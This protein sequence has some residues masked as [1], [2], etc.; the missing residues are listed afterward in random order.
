LAVQ[1]GKIP[2][3]TMHM[4]KGLEFRSVVIM[5]CDAD[6]IPDMSRFVSEDASEI[7]ALNASERQ[8]LYVA[9][10]RARDELVVSSAGLQSEYI[11]DLDTVAAR[12]RL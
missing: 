6:V 9:M 12:N 7:Q 3:L 2:L 8:L 4:A 1:P 10:T 5:A 11:V